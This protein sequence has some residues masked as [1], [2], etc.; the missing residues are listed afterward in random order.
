M[1]NLLTWWRNRWTLRDRWNYGWSN[2]R[3]TM[4]DI[5]RFY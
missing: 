4:R 2:P 5:E 3:K 1:K